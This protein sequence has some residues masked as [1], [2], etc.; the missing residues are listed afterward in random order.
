MR[1]AVIA[2]ICV[3]ILGLAART[4]VSADPPPP[5]LR[6]AVPLACP[7]GIVCMVQNYV[8]HDPGP[9]ARDHTCG[10]LATDGHQGI[11]IRVPGLRE[12]SL[13]VP[14]VAAAAGVVRRVRDGI[15][16]V[17]IRDAGPPPPGAVAGNT[18]VVDHPGGWQ[19]QYSHLRRGSIA[20]HPGQLVTAG[21]RLG[22]VG[23]SGNTEFPH[24]HFVVRY[25]GG[26]R[27]PYT[28]RPPGRGCG[29]PGRVLWT[30]AAA[31]T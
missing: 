7:P 15:P 4:V 17:S 14:V 1:T 10:P 24:V 21:T 11:D 2:L 23:L 16:D 18:V 25:R 26:A 28:G 27:D 19:T 20:V 29:A 13:G 31:A 22:L 9:G 8:D 3:P 30:P 6:L 12:M 5:T